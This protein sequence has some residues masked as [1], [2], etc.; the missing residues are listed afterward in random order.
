MIE[1]GD[2]KPKCF[3]EKTVNPATQH[4]ESPDALWHKCEACDELVFRQVLERNLYICPSCGYYFPFPA[5]QRLRHILS[6]D[7][8]TDLFPTSAPPTLLQS[9]NLTDL[10]AQTACL[11]LPDRIIAAGEGKISGYPT[12]L[13]VVHPFSLPQR[14]HFI[15]L[16]IAIR[17]ALM[18]AF[19]L[20]CVYSNEAVPKLREIDRPI[21]SELSFAEITYL[22][23]EM[24]KLS[25][26]RL[27]Q[28]TVLTDANAGA[29][30]TRFPT[31]DFVLVEGANVST[32]TPTAQ[33]PVA[34]T[35]M[36]EAP[37][38]ELPNCDAFVD[39]YIPR[40][41]LPETLGKLLSF[42]PPHSVESRSSNQ[43]GIP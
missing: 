39:R 40:E 17:T 22:S 25:K 7:S 13:T 34:D 29:L 5:E 18:K 38:L 1:D 3:T 31:G 8:W 30:S 10:V 6:P 19:P 35:R 23:T 24:A 28:I 26:T 4:K 12:I 43:D 21:T 2:Y 20:I 37:S 42:F 11:D 16:M 15:T 14:L 27:P 36:K 32:H 9:L 33:S 41:E